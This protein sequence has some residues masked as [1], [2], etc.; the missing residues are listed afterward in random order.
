VEE[1]IRVRLEKAGESFNLVGTKRTFTQ[2]ELEEILDKTPE[3]ISPNVVLRPLYQ[4][5]ILPNL[6]YVGGPGELAYWLEFKKLFERSSV[7]FP[8]LMPRNFVSVVDKITESKIEKLH[9]NVGDFY[10][11]EQEL[12]KELQIKKDAIFDL[13]PEKES[14]SDFY[15]KILEKA[16]ATDKTLSGS[17]SAE[18]QRTLNGFERIIGKTNRA[19][20]R[21]YETEI[22]QLSGIKQRLFPKNVPQERYENFSSLY[23]SYG[24]NFIKEI[25]AKTDPLLLEPSIFIE[26]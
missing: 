17:V 22:H 26:E 24:K 6:A 4:Q 3:K 13:A 16:S 7:L 8:I 12:I 21:K 18:L 25:K 1:G 9:F 20:R 15:S 2:K 10:K 14:I 23:L 11:P 5:V 19:I